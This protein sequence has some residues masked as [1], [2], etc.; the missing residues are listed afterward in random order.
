MKSGTHLCFCLV[1]CPSPSIRKIGNQPRALNW[2]GFELAGYTRG[3]A[4]SEEGEGKGTN[5]VEEMS[6]SVRILLR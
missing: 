5:E 6:D 1:V 2:R 4:G 3:T